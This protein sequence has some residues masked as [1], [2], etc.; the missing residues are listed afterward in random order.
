MAGGIAASKINTSFQSF[1]KSNTEA[2]EP[3]SNG[4]RK[5]FSKMTIP[6]AIIMLL[7]FG[8]L[9]IR[10]TDKIAIGVR[11]EERT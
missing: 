3:A 2:T 5:S 8:N 1:G 4:L 10:P 9:N 7:I 11:A 6:R